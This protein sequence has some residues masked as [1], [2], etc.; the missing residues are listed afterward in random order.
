MGSSTLIERET[1]TGADEGPHLLITGG[2]H[3]DEFEPMAAARRLRAVL[4]GL[5][6]R[7][8]V[9]LVP[10]VN[11]PAFERGE[12]TGPDGLD[13]ARTCP[14]D[15]KGSETERIAHE[16][17]GLIRQADYYV[18]LH[19]GGTRLTIEPLVGYML[20]DD[21]AVLERQRNMARAFNLPIV[22]GTSSRLEGRSLSVARDAGVPAVYA[23][24]GG[25]GGC[26]QAGVTAYVEGCLNVATR[27]GM[28][29]RPEWESRV[30]FV[31]ED[32]RDESGHL[33]VQYPS[34]SAGFFEPGVTLGTMVAAG[35]VLGQ[36]VDE[37]GN[38]VV[39][40]RA[41]EAGLILLLR[42]FPRVERGDTLAVVL[43]ICEPGSLHIARQ[44]QRTQGNLACN[45]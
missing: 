7:G 27:L 32:H 25:G 8:R 3:G 17:S 1:L 42:S 9:T 45:S 37:L 23:E 12:R 22:W 34:P 38:G 18:D 36:V 5:L 26:E 31:V 15:P 44:G 16:L 6:R 4:P 14:G 20:H 2:V 11:R 21:A 35:D 39:G 40:V 30:R 33:Q 24:Y 13:L 43:P 29:D 10:V 28:V 19:T 41:E